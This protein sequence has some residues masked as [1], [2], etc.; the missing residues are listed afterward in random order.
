MTSCN[1]SFLVDPTLFAKNQK[2]DFTAYYVTIYGYDPA[3]YCRC[4]FADDPRGSGTARHFK[5]RLSAFEHLVRRKTLLQR[6]FPLYRF[7]WNVYEISWCTSDPDPYADPLL[8][9]YGEWKPVYEMDQVP[10]VFGETEDE[11]VSKS[12]LLV[13]S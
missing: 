7:E 9:A 4:K 13:E 1:A 6:R 2:N 3:D 12:S 11:R 8:T 5:N 10:D